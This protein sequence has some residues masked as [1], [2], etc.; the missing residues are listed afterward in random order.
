M[1][2]SWGINQTWPTSGP[3]GYITPAALG[4]PQRFKSGDQISNGP[5]VGRVAT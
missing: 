1:L 4:G 2:Y 5:Q 3:G